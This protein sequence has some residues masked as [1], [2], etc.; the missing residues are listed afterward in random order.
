MIARLK[1][2]RSALFLPASNPRAI[3]KARGLGADLVI[4]DLEDAVRDEDKDAARI[5]A[6]EAA[7]QGF[8][9]AL[10]AIRVNGTGSGEHRVDVEAVR[11]SAADLGVLPM[12]DQRTRLAGFVSDVGK[13]VLAMIET[14]RAVIDAAR[15]AAVEGVVGFIAGTNDLCAATGIR[16]GGA[17]AGLVTALQTILL[18]ARAAGIAA[19]DGVY[20]AIDDAD[21]FEAEARQGASFG[22][23][24][25]ALVHP[26]QVDP[27][28]RIFGSSPAD[29]E[30]AEAL[31]A[32]A[33]GGAERFR[34]RMVEA[35]HVEQARQVL[36]RARRAS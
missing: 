20:N 21:G 17:R 28:N 12:I 33:S 5:A 8:G 29:I 6:V 10:V 7:G 35:L 9:D 22:F 13:P 18:G 1:A 30:D 36:A 14:P 11:A 19:F 25:K 32:A 31:I 15:I 4:L 2:V 27:A 3:A 16:N 23:D 24:G 34:G 26:S